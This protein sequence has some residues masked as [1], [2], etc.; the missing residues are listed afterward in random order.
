MTTLTELDAA[1][2]YH[3]AAKRLLAAYHDQIE[4]DA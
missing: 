1:Q 4:E 2:V 3:N